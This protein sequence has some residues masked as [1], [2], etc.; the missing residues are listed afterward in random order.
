MNK[1]IFTIKKKKKSLLASSNPIEIIYS[2]ALLNMKVCPFLPLYLA[3]LLVFPAVLFLLFS[4]SV[5][6]KISS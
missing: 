2:L 6:A 5:W 4:F 3:T 1:D